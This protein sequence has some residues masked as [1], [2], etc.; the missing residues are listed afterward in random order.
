[1]RN[2]G[3]FCLVS[4]FSAFAFTATYSGAG[5]YK[6][7][8]GDSGEYTVVATIEKTGEG[9][10]NINQTINL[11]NKT[12]NTSTILQKIDDTFFNVVDA[13]S[14][15][16]VGDGYCWPL[17]TAGDKICHSYAKKYDFVTE[18]TIKIIGTTLH[19]VGSHKDRNTGEKITWKDRLVLQANCSCGG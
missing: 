10:M 2:V 4:L 7:N 13:E 3:T 16:V 1:M 19:R 14:G 9:S 15:N 11:E 6:T 8:A 18:S 5:N 12:L 17:E